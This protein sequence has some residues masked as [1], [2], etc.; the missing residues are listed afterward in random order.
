M[1]NQT[2]W[3]LLLCLATLCLAGCAQEIEKRAGSQR[4]WMDATGG[5]FNGEARNGN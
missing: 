4:A 3:S 5:G 1:K 2:G